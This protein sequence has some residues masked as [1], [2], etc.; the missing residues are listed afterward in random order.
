MSVCLF[1]LRDTVL[2]TA[3]GVDWHGHQGEEL[4]SPTYTKAVLAT[5]QFQSTFRAIKNCLPDFRTIRV[6]CF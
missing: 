4:T 6:F 3:G 2:T 1:K 5:T